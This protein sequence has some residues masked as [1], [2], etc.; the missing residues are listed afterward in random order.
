MATFSCE[1]IPGHGLLLVPPSQAGFTALVE[2]IRPHAP[3]PL[4]ARLD[5]AAVL[6]NHG[7]APLAGLTLEW[8]FEEL[9]GRRFEHRATFLFGRTLLLPFGASA[10]DLASALYWQTILPGSRRLLTGEGIFGGNGDVRPPAPEETPRGGFAGG[11]GGLHPHE[12][13]IFRRVELAIDGA[14]FLDGEFTGPN[15]S[16]IWEAVYYE[17]EVRLETARAARAAL[18]RGGGTAE[19]L[20]AAAG[21]CGAP[22][23][24][25]GSPP[26]LTSESVS[27]GDFRLWH[28]SQL[29]GWLQRL[30]RLKGDEAILSMLL[31]WL[32]APVPA[33]RRS[34]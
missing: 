31:A 17:A 18:H 28:R 27:A 6:D 32:D 4:P 29:A 13:N 26:W 34:M 33:L 1:G 14:F 12:P 25:S 5:H 8:R 3:C 2:A 23:Q 11:A 10:E 20:A 19:A 15:R 16:H 21:Y 24:G 9:S 7:R 22:A 30:G